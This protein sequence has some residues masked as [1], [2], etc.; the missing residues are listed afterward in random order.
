NLKTSTL[1]GAENPGRGAPNHR[2]GRG[3]RRSTSMTSGQVSKL[4]LDYFDLGTGSADL[5][6]KALGMVVKDH[7]V[8]H[9]TISGVSI[10]A[11]GGKFNANSSCDLDEAANRPYS[12]SEGAT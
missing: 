5:L 12:R 7:N 9:N 11:L 6:A 8:T 2:K 10:S 4:D 1:G 3:H